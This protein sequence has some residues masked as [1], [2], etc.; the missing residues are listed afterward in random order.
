MCGGRSPESSEGDAGTLE[1]IIDRS[2][3]L[4]SLAWEAYELSS[5]LSKSLK[6]LSRLT[7]SG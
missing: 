2:I 6:G 1:D 4:S 5:D 7:L 3:P